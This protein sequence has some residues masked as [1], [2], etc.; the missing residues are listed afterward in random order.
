MWR[1]LLPV[2]VLVILCSNALPQSAELPKLERF[3][4]S[5]VDP[6][7][8]ACTDFYQYTCSKWIAAH[9]IPPDMTETSVMLPLYL[10]N[11]TI[12]RNA[13]E[14]AAEDTH[15]TGSERQ[16]GDF[17]RSCMDESGRAAHSLEWLRPH[18]A[19]IAGC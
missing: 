10:Y 9:P 3:E 17:W 16:I 18:L 4:P 2:G 19:T 13:L 7:K 14:K 5:L 12:L 6:S 8:D 15:A 11:Q 1:G